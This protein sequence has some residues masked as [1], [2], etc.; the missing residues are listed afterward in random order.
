MRDLPAVILTATI[1]AYWFAVGL[2]IARTSKR[3]RRLS[4]LV[5]EQRLER[6]MWVI[7][8]PVILAWII[9]PY[10]AT[11]QTSPLLAAPGLARSRPGFSGLRWAASMGGVLCWLVTMECWARMGKSWRMG[12]TR[13]R[14]ELISDGL[15]A[16]I[17]H[18][19]YAF[20]ILLMLCTVVVVPTMPMLAVAVLHIALMILKARNEER[21]LL[22]LH[23]GAYARYCRE[24]GRFFP[25]L[26]SRGPSPD[27]GDPG[28]IVRP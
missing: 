14:T 26:R 22:S 6:L 25:L 16:Y 20:S 4:G 12:V 10:L 19:I 9:L 18:P 8:V 13:E 7:W 11:S 2:M 24:T 5:P 15:Y 28:G 27:E 17:R 3:A 23:G 1:W 21:F